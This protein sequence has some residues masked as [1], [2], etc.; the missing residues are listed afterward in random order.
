MVRI[1]TGVVLMGASQVRHRL[2]PVTAAVVRHEA[3]VKE[4]VTQFEAAPAANAGNSHVY[5]ND[6]GRSGRVT[7]GCQRSGCGSNSRSIN[8][9]QR[10]G[11]R[12]SGRSTRITG[13]WQGWPRHEH[14]GTSTVCMQRHIRKVLSHVSGR[15]SSGRST[16]GCRRNG[17][18]M[19]DHG[20]ATS[21]RPHKRLR[22]AIGCSR[23]DRERM[24]RYKRPQ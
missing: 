8:S 23:S 24:P 5:T 21:G 18:G 12:I 11:R 13:G 19:S 1:R 7:R 2:S 3:P 17:R 20:T 9:C 15:G 4:K 14:I 22:S 10:S 16:N 6:H